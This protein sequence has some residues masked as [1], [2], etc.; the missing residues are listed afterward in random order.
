[1]LTYQNHILNQELTII[2]A[3]KVI[4][5]ISKA[6]LVLFVV[7]ENN[8]M[9]GT[10]TD[11]D[12]RRAL[13]SGKDINSK[14]H[15]AMNRNF[16]YLRFGVDD[17]PEHLREQKQFRMRLVPIVDENNHIVEIIDLDRFK[18]KLPIDA[19]L[20]AGGKGERL[21][22]L[23]EKTPKPLL[24]LGDKPIV[25]YIV[26]HIASFGIKNIS[27]T[28]NYLHEQIEEHFE[29]P[30]GDVMVRTVLEPRFLGTI[31]SILF[32]EEFH[33]DTVLLM[34]SDAITDLDLEKFYLHF[35]E[36]GA[37]MSIA[38]IPYDISVP[39]GIF[40]LDGRNVK[41]VLEK[42][43]YNY[44]ANSGIYLIK[45]ECLDLIPKDTFFN[46][47]DFMEMLISKGHKVIR[48]PLNGTWLDIGSPQ[49]YRKAQEI[50]K[51]MSFGK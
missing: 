22:P 25:D 30:V 18:T 15:H 1:M 39:Y 34:N 46:A 32:V 28:T 24:P 44:Y 14:V 2:D 41:G 38:A 6:P 36:H 7:D 47:T 19:V 29:K 35:K 40:E 16:R 43:T 37:D 12:I 26:E 10:M 48:Y 13:I 21:R 51:H 31:G 49:E 23:T 45:R 3:L 17:D 11:G 9:V 20:M 42:P 4:N 33:N 8:S 50:V 27:V 5:S